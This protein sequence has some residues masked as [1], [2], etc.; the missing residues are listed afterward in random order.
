MPAMPPVT[1]DER[2]AAERARLAVAPF[3]GV[4]FDPSAVPDLAAVTSPPYDVVNAAGARRLEALHPL[5][6]VR[7][8]LP[9]AGGDSASGRHAD[10]AATL[11]EW[12]S[13]GILRPDAEPSMYVYDQQHQGVSSRGILAAVGLRRP[14]DRV[15]LPHEDVMPGPVQDRLELMRAT[16][17][18]L[19][20]ILLVYD[21]GQATGELIWEAAERLPLVDATTDDGARHRIWAISD[22][23]RLDMIADDLAP[24]QALIA[25]GH[26]RYETYLKLQTERRLAGDGAGPWDFGLALLVDNADYPLHLGAISRV[27]ERLPLAEAVTSAQTVFATIT[28]CVSLEE[29][30]RALESSSGRHPFLLTDGVTFTLLA[31]PDPRHLPATGSGPF[32]T[33]LRA[34]DATVLHAVLLE[35]VWRVPDDTGRIRYVHEVGDAVR[36]ARETA[37]TAVLMRPVTVADVVAVAA[38]GQRMPRKS[39]SFGPKPR[40]GFV[41]RLFDA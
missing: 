19:E 29:G 17:A 20:P 41:L 28:R 30:Q 13:E 24:R 34:F 31:D 16:N 21:G 22:P 12:L 10:A 40:T 5:N 27:V 1:P 2:D 14:E 35:Q 3:R 38:R 37:G 36:A 32:T 15:V 23:G 26:H 7:L 33:Q 11:V 18:N 8:I 9:R 4:R 39:T 25:D 6:V